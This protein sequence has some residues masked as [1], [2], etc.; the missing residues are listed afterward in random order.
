MT[1]LHTGAR[2]LLLT[3]LL[4]LPVPGT[5]AEDKHREL[6]Q[7]RTRIRDAVT[8]KK[9]LESDIGKA[10]D[11]LRRK[12]LAL[13]EANGRLAELRLA[14]AEKRTRLEALTTESANDTGTLAAERDR[15]AR[16]LRAHYAMGRQQ[17]LKLALNLDDPERFGRLLT[18]H[19]MVARARTEQVSAAG[20]RLQNTTLIA[21]NIRL[22][23]EKLEFLEAEQRRLIDNIDQ[24]REARKQTVA[25]LSSEL[26]EQNQALRELRADKRALEKLL[27]S[28]P[29]V[30]EPAV[31]SAPS[32]GYGL[33]AAKGRLPWPTAGRV[34]RSFTDRPNNDSELPPHGV[35]IEA[36]AGTA[37][38]AIGGGRVRFADWFQGFGLLL[39][40]DHGGG[41]MSLYGHNQS[42]N[43]KSGDNV[44]EGE[45]IAAVGDS[46]GQ[47]A[48]G[49]YFAIRHNGKP[50]DPAQWCR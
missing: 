46:G 38:H 1:G 4:S 12:E 30:A 48:S 9:R 8:E 25:A 16:I 27:Y 41:Y 49:L 32:A 14:I 28:L 40:I 33:A 37:V 50:L 34:T 47:Q 2:L 43:K 10:R 39:I 31:Q 45:V 7:L 20:R 29:A 11:D 42:L 15:L 17:R 19:D 21:E 5:T 36:A 26:K 23:T 18:F 13:A 3:V 22:E 6:E 24:L 35:L 44:Q